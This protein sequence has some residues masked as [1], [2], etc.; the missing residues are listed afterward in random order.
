MVDRRKLGPQFVEG[1]LG[2]EDIHPS[3]SHGN[4]VKQ[5]LTGEVAKHIMERAGIS[6]VEPMD[7]R[8]RLEETEGPVMRTEHRREM[9][10]RDEPL[11]STQKGL[12]GQVLKA[13]GMGMAPESHPISGGKYVPE[14]VTDHY[15][16]GR[17]ATWLLDGHH[18]IISNRLGKNRVNDPEAD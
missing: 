18:R 15:D 6:Q 2:L 9:P 13:Y 3:L 17:E 4:R 14:L 12:S 10:A 11:N 7:M 1:G 8:P 16:S 5:N